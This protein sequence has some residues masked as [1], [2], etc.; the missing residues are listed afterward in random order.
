MNKFIAL[1]NFVAANEIG[2]YPD[3]DIKRDFHRL[4][5]LVLNS[6]KIELDHEHSEIRSN[7]GG[8]AVSG[9]ITLHTDRLYVQIS[10]GYMG[11]Q[12]MYRSCEGTKDFTGGTNRFLSLEEFARRTSHYIEMMKREA[13]KAN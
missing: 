7:M 2:N 6:I 11:K 12:I 10:E 5:K 9:E 1:A 13:R 3:P 8:I 4:S